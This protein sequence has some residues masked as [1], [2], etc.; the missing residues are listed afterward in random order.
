M[1]DLVPEN[2]FYRKVNRVID[3]SF[4]RELVKDKYCADNGRPSAA[5]E[6]I[7]RI[8][9]IGYFENFSE[10]RLWNELQMHA[11][12]RWFCKLEF[13]DLVPDRSTWIKTRQRWGME[14]FDL[15]FRRIVEQCIQSGLVKGNL[16]AIDGTQVEANAA[17]TSLEAITPVVSIDEY[18]NRLQMEPTKATDDKSEKPARSSGDPDFRGEKFSNQTHRSTTDPDARL[19]RKNSAHEAKLS[20]L[21]HDALDV[22]SGV[23][24]DTEAT[25]AHGRAERETAIE[26]LERLGR[27]VFALM[28]KNYRAGEFLHKLRHQGIHPLVSMDS[29][30][31]EVVP[32]WKRRTFKLDCYRRRHNLFNEI[33]ARNYARRLNRKRVFSKTYKLRIK[34]EHKFAEAKECHGL[35]R[36]RGYGLENMKIQARLTAT[37]QN[38]KRLVR[39]LTRSKPNKA[40]GVQTTAVR[41]KEGFSVFKVLPFFSFSVSNFGLDLV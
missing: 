16:V 40:T 14:V 3:F 24:L 1:E 26:F 41:F 28:D 38:I 6:T 32:V 13:N 15:I 18:L 7:M 25:L 34:I 36:A 4:I 39:H 8:M 20:Y 21:V 22:R 19:Y 37:V 23:I 12:Y 35:D 27:N 31:F 2:Y 9:L 30:D 33:K 5:P 17:V 10:L 11:G 29:L